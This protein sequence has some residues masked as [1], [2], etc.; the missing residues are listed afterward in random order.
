[1]AALPVVLVQLVRCLSRP[2]NDQSVVRLVDCAEVNEGIRKSLKELKMKKS[3][4]RRQTNNEG[5]T[6]SSLFSLRQQSASSGARHYVLPKVD[7]V[8]RNSHAT[9]T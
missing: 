7:S 6:I 5:T 8:L 1:V 3:Q 9:I 2:P 4:V